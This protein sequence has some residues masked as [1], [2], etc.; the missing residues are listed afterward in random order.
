[1]YLTKAAIRDNSTKDLSAIK[2]RKNRFYILQ[3]IYKEKTVG[4]PEY[5][6]AEVPNWTRSAICPIPR[7]SNG[8]LLAARLHTKPRG[9]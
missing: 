7:Y 3:K 1:L 2:A 5:D 4:K 6:A 9:S 8:A